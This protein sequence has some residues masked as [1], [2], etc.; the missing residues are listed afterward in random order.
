MGGAINGILAGSGAGRGELASASCWPS[1]SSTW[2]RPGT[3]R[4]GCALSG[5]ERSSSQN[6]NG[7]DVMLASSAPS[8][9]DHPSFA[10]PGRK[11]KL[12]RGRGELPEE[13]QVTLPI[14]SDS[15]PRPTEQVKRGLGRRA[16]AA[17]GAWSAVPG[18]QALPA[19]L[20]P[21]RPSAMGNTSSERAALERQAGHKTPRRD[22]SGGSKDGD[23]PKILMDSPEDAD[24]F[25]SEEIKVLSRGA[26]GP[27]GLRLRGGPLG[28][29]SRHIPSVT[30]GG[31]WPRHSP[32]CCPGTCA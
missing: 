17:R 27:S 7:S 9:T 2:E 6:G 20:C 28:C 14:L 11:R 3:T 29:C 22:S 30:P 5:R 25:H 21:R 10:G 18:V 4:C 13:C 31:S 1:G 24:I 26:P 8:R 15:Q 23:R 16:R 32:L 19:S 12:L